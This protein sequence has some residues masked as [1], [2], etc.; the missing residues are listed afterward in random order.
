MKASE[1][2]TQLKVLLPQLTNLFT[3]EI[4]IASLTRS[5]SIITAQCGEI[6]NLVA[7]D[8]VAIVGAVTQITISSLTR[9]GV[10][11][12][13]VTATNHDLSESIATAVTL[14][15]ADEAEFRGTF[16]LISVLN[17]K[18]VSFVMVDS[19]P[20][21]ASGSPVLEGAE[22][23]LRD[24][25]ST[26]PVLDTPT[27]TSFTFTES[28][29]GL[30]DPLG[31]IVARVKPR[32]SAGIS[33]ERCRDAYTEE[34]PGSYWIFVVLGPVD[35]SKNRKIGSDS[36]DNQN[37][38]NE[39]RQQIIQ[40]FSIFVFVPVTGEVAAR[41]ARDDQED[42]FPLI[43]RS[44]LFSQFESGLAVGKQGYAQ[45]VSHEIF[46]Y[47]TAVYIHAFTYQQTVDLIFGDTTG[48]ALDVA[49]RNIDLTV[50]P[51]LGGADELTQSAIDLDEVAL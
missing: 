20:T 35:A 3:D 19:G 15:G 25:N 33:I 49:F 8:A 24:Y 37:R 10:V 26:Y 30:L 18:T 47:N 4:S 5:G 48:F 50:T 43:C 51:L 13:L 7:G 22:S 46:D 32:I 1:I 2:V 9:S 42:L 38:G 40:P 6:H 28:S 41:E 12:T 39:F 17:R 11:G 14:S 23:P 45:F 21:T 27:T 34:N 36:L 44:V 31:T 16:V 29:T